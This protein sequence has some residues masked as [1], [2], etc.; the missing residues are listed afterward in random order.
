MV[1]VV[2]V[3]HL[4]EE[5]QNDLMVFQLMSRPMWHI[6][7]AGKAEFWAKGVL[8]VGMGNLEAV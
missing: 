3:F 1:G 2:A 6:C 7:E 5:L 8:E 4:T